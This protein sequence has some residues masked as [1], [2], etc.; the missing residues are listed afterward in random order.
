[1]GNF[2]NMTNTPAEKAKKL[3]EGLEYLKANAG[4]QT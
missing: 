2:M 4:N 3:T 1:M